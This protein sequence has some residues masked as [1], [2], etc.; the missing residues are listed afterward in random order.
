MKYKLTENTI[1]HDG[2]TLY[3]IQ[4]LSNGELGGYIES[5]KNLS[6]EGSCWVSGNAVV[7]GN[8]RVSSYAQVYGYVWVS[9]NAKVSGNAQVYGNAMVYG[10]AVVYGN[11]RL[12]TG[13]FEAGDIEIQQEPLIESE[14]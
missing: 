5:E 4:R 7:C 6:Q 9:G 14:T 3:Q 12:N 10:N 11:A 2:R 13:E 8:A 1:Q